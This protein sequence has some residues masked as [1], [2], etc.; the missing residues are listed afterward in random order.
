MSLILFP[1]SCIHHTCC[2]QE[3]SCPKCGDKRPFSFF[4][5]FLND[6]LGPELAE[7]ARRR[8]D[9]ETKGS[10]LLCRALSERL[11]KTLHD[12]HEALYV[13]LPLMSHLCEYDGDL[14]MATRY[15]HVRLEVLQSVTSALS[16]EKMDMHR[17]LSR[18]LEMRA[19]D[20]TLPQQLREGFMRKAEEHKRIAEECRM[21]CLGSR[22]LI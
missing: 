1:R 17:R 10:A 11:G 3:F 6:V 2:A 7:L 5:S 18:L 15:A 19:A 14:V 21:V 12:F 16:L 22:G 13:S 9:G 4:T 8:N 20:S